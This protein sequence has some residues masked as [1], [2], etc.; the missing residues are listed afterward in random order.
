MKT[1]GEGQG[2]RYGMDPGG[3]VHATFARGWSRDWCKPG[4]FFTKGEV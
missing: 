2:R 4:E 1:L 3:R